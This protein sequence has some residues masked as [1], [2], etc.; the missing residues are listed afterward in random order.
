[1]TPCSLRFLIVAF[2][3][4]EY[5]HIYIIR[6]KV[7]SQL[8]TNHFTE[9][10]TEWP[11]ITF[12]ITVCAVTRQRSGRMRNFCSIRGRDERA[13]CTRKRPKWRW[14]PRRH[15]FNRYRG[16]LAGTEP[17]K[18]EGEPGTEYEW[19]Y[20]Y[21][22]VINEVF[23]LLGYYA[24]K[25][26][27]HLPTFYDNL[28]VLSSRVKQFKKSAWSAGPWKG[29]AIDCSETLVIKSSQKSENLNNIPHRRRKARRRITHQKKK[30][31]AEEIYIFS[32]VFKS[33]FVYIFLLQSSM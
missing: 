31:F 1:V 27:N 16:P 13:V 32:P 17:A 30:I 12:H 15:L 9:C 14:C 3:L 29:G 33:A 6:R 28:S 5:V 24:A 11:A 10:G 8:Q 20:G 4:R 2:L 7:T 26:G 21:R 25:I 22:R 23:V 19:F 18:F